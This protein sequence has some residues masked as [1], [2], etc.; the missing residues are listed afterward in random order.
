MAE[1]T[2]PTV[3][4]VVDA[5]VTAA[6]KKQVNASIPLD[7]Y[8]ALEGYAFGT[9]RKVSELIRDIVLEYAKTNAAEIESRG[10]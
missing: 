7:V 9:R 4:D 2:T 6:K 1:K 10:V 3:Q 8:D 5:K